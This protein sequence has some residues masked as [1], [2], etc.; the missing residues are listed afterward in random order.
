MRGSAKKPPRCIRENARLSPAPRRASTAPPYPCSSTL[1]LS[2]TFTQLC[3][4]P[5]PVHFQPGYIPLLKIPLPWQPSHLTLWH[6]TISSLSFFDLSSP[7]TATSCPLVQLYPGLVFEGHLLSPS[8]LHSPSTSPSS[9]PELHSPGGAA[10]EGCRLTLTAVSQVVCPGSCK[11][12]R[13][14]CQ[15]GTSAPGNAEL[16]SCQPHGSSLGLL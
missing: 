14:G 5:A 11:E 15:G 6:S 2:S 7:S 1:L 13:A 10:V 8:F 3:L 4:L 9:G 12:S 16:P